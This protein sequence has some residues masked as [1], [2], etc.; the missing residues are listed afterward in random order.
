[1]PKTYLELL[2]AY[3]Y[4][5][6]EALRGLADAAQVILDA[7]ANVSIREAIG[8]LELIRDAMDCLETYQQFQPD[9]FNCRDIN[10]QLR[11]QTWTGAQKS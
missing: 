3:R 9:A 6:L 2:D 10:I 11:Q 7:P 4:P 8:D 5:S 1:M